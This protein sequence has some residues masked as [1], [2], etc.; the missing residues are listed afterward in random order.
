M[1]ADKI[2]IFQETKG[3]KRDPRFDPLCGE[4]DKDQFRYKK[5]SLSPF[6][7]YLYPPRFIGSLIFFYPS[8]KIYSFK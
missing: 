6:G 3:A 2:I 5:C 8:S 1:K 4:F 7:Y